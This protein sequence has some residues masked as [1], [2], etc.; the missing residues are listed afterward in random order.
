MPLPLLLRLPTNFGAKLK[1]EFETC[2]NEDGSFFIKNFIF[3]NMKSLLFFICISLFALMGCASSEP[4]P[5]T[6]TVDTDQIRA[7]ASQAY[8]ELDAESK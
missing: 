3:T 6:Q 5:Q 1:G 2:P 7:N 4:A 8:Q